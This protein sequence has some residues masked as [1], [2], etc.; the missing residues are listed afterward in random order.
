MHVRV[1]EAAKRGNDFSVR[2]TRFGLDF[3][4]R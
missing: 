3:V 1:R 2:A 4:N